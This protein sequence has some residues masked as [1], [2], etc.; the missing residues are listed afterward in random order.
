MQTHDMLTTKIEPD[1]TQIIKEEI[2]DFIIEVIDLSGKEA[3]AI[4]RE[5]AAT[6]QRMVDRVIGLNE[7]P[8]FDMRVSIID[9]IKS[10]IHL[11]I[12]MLIADASS[13]HV[14][15]RQL[16]YFYNNPAEYPEKPRM[17]FRDYVLSLQ[18]YQKAEGYKN[19][20]KYWNHKF[21]KMF[22]G[23]QLPMNNSSLSSASF[24][25]RQLKGVLE[26]WGA[27]K[28]RAGKLSVAPSIPLLTAYGEVFSAWL[29]HSPFSIV[30]P[31]W[32]RLPVHSDIEEV[33]GDFT[34]MSWVA[35]T[36]ER[37]S[38]EE[39]VQRNHN[40]VE[41]DLSHRAVSGLKALRKIVMRGGHKGLFTFPVVFTNLMSV[42]A[43]EGHGFKKLEMLSKTPQVYVDSMSEEHDGRLYFYWDVAKGIYP[44]GMIEEIFSGYDRLLHALAEDP[45]SWGNM[46][47]DRLVNAQPEKYRLGAETPGGFVYEQ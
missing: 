19:S 21:E 39:K 23:P 29:D 8:Y 37:M 5:L 4:R 42:P 7:W 11:S 34:S 32:E 12:D 25:R 44:E 43:V 33:V 45:A 13:I 9:A 10:R 46:D 30:I 3:Y 22:P 38:F 27:L 35:F 41:E 20:I 1:G 26:N 28:E 2:P 47:F 31:C 18:A 36:G 40:V 6:K 15:M 24:D 14:L 17:S 16:F